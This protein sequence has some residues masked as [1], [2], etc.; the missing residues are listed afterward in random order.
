MLR[1][2]IE[3][4]AN[5]VKK[6]SVQR[7]Y[8]VTQYALT[9]FGGAGGQ[10]ACAVADRLGIRQILIHPFSGILSAYG[11]GLADIKATT[12]F[13]VGRILSPDTLK[14]IHQKCVSSRQDLLAKLAMQ[15]VSEKASRTHF[16]AHLKY[17]GTDTTIEVD[18]TD[19]VTMQEKFNAIHQQRFGFVNRQRLS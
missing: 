2:A 8:D 17:R 7:G 4:M 16:R 13:T 5:A 10:H 18:I 12:Q 15:G 1:I 3:N 19:C 9:C 11:M 14:N 6:I